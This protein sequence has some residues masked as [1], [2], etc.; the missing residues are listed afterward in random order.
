DDSANRRIILAEGFLATDEILTRAYKILKNLRIDDFGIRKNLEVY[1]VFSATERL[2]MEAV[3][4]GGN[5]QD[6]HEVIR[7]RSLQAWE[8]IRNGEN[9]PLKDLLMA[10]ERVLNFIPKDEIPELLNAGAHVGT[11]PQRAK[12]M[13]M[14]IRESLKGGA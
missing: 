6:L 13:A 14:T 5:R 10:D 8:A 3:K 7:E 12:K 1:G 2:L 4:R 11:A 9:N